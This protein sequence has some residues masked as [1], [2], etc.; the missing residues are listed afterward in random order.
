MGIYMGES[1]W[2][3]SGYTIMNGIAKFSWIGV[4]CGII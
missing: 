4:I 1:G 3:V 2:T